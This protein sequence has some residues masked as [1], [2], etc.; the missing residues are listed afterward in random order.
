[1]R[2]VGKFELIERTLQVTRN[3]LYD[4][5]NVINEYKANLELALLKKKIE[6]KGLNILM[7]KFVKKPTPLDSKFRK[8]SMSGQVKAKSDLQDFSGIEEGSSVRMQIY[9]ENEK[10]ENNSS[11]DGYENVSQ[12]LDISSKYTPRA[13][14]VEKDQIEKAQEKFAKLDKSCNSVNQSNNALM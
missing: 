13:S 6:Q 8:E 11:I 9:P 14:F 10:S 7:N 5:E 1:M 4:L 12:D 2:V 3:V